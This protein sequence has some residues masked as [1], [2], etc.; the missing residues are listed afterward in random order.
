LQEASSRCV[1]DGRE[2][3]EDLSGEFSLACRAY[4]ECPGQLNN[5]QAENFNQFYTRLNQSLVKQL[6]FFLAKLCINESGEFWW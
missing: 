1:G 6:F 4:I 2:E 3:I 5:T